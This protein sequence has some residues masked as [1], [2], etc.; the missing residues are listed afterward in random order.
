MKRATQILHNAGHAICLLTLASSLVT[1]SLH[2]E[3]PPEKPSG[4]TAKT[5]PDAPE[6][7]APAV[8][9][10]PLF[11]MIEPPKNVAAID[12]DGAV[13]SSASPLSATSSQAAAPEAPAAPAKLDMGFFHRLG[14]AYTADWGGSGPGTAVPQSARRGTPAP[15]F[16]P[17]YPATDWPIGGTTV[18]GVP[19]GQTYPLMQ[20][21]NENKG[22]N[23]IYGYIE[24]G[25]NGSTN[26]KTNAGK[27]ITANAPAAYDVFSNTVELDQAA[28]YFEKVEDTAQTD[29]VD[30]GYRLTLLYGTDYRF[31]TSHGILSQQ[32]LV[33]NAQYGFDP[34]MF[35]IDGYFPHIGKGTVV[36]IGRYI[37]LP[38]IEAQL[39]PNNYSYSH[40]I[41]Y[42]Y[43]CYT[44][45]GVN[46]T[47]KL[48][49]HWTVQA[50]LSPGCDT[51]PWTT[52]AK[53]TG[54][55]CLVYTW[56]N[57]GDVVNTCDNTINDGK[58]AYNN[59]TAFYSTWYHRINKNW[60]TDTEG[61]YQYMKDAPNMYWYNSGTPRTV[62]T[63]WPE[64]NGAGVN[65][66]FGAVCQDPRR[67][68][69]QQSSRCYAGEWALTNY[70]E[71]NFW[72][73]EAS[74]NIRNEVVND[75]KGQRSGTPTYYEEHMVGFDFWSGSTVT[76][77]P[78]LSYTRCYSKY[79]TI[80]GKPV[81]C[82]DVAPGASIAS[83]TSEGIGGL[84]NPAGRGKTQSLTL[85]ADVIFHF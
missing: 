29:H 2:A 10:Q 65:L 36:R 84:F 7:T 15:I 53:V 57:G 82:T 62:T 34:V 21:V 71:H 61:W 73:N 35:Y 56:S 46:A 75:I 28:L 85:S 77:R 63:P 16:S 12:A 47:V 37:S 68:A 74:L 78:E 26:N 30:W 80:D 22:A 41:L 81:S 60:H 6:A 23:K 54:N 50:G 8:S 39:A 5:L 38:D 49:D 45:V 42:T 48:S 52:D 44:Q 17:P 13:S 9:Q 66:N 69:S 79:K 24:V 55:A 51:A 20:A 33:K 19:D 58:Y 72:N 18:I 43:D 11:S 70:V 25:G 31:T 3:T 14:R 83:D 76:F 64:T 59:L 4:G 67:P 1:L 40:S 27:G 32:L